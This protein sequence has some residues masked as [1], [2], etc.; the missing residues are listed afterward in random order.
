M[1]PEEKIAFLIDAALQSIEAADSINWGQGH[2]MP[3]NLADALEYLE[4][5]VKAARSK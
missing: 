3:S 4:S 5:A 1:T 2:I